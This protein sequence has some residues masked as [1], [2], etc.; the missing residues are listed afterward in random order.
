MGGNWF[1]EA[2]SALHDINLNVSI[3]HLT[4]FNGTAHINTNIFTNFTATSTGIITFDITKVSTN[5]KASMVLNN[6]VSYL[7]AGIDL[8]ANSRY[9]FEDYVQKNDVLNLRFNDSTQAIVDVYFR[10]G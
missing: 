6:T 3:G 4:S 5:C 2:L 7:Q 1:S 8:T 10:E 9:A